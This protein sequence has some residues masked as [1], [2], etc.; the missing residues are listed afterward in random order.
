MKISDT[1]K[2]AGLAILLAM[3]LTGCDSDDDSVVVTPPPIV[4]PGPD[5]TPDPDPI[6]DLDPTPGNGAPHC[7]VLM[8]KSM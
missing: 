4:D 3:T 1:I 7:K 5:P 8:S 2:A 6:P